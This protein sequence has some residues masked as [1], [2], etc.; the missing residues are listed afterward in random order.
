MAE[1]KCP[2]T[3]AS[4]KLLECGLNSPP[5]PPVP[6]LRGGT[7]PIGAVSQE[8]RPGSLWV[9]LKDDEGAGGLGEGL[10]D[11]R[12]RHKTVRVRARPPGGCPFPKPGGPEYR[13]VRGSRESPPG[14]A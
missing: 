12:Q 14:P 13:S 2:R 11:L 10:E 6:A 9:E 5:C 8:E 1:K 4:L 7:C 3:P